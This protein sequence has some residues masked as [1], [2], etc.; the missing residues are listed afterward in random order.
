MTA[1]PAARPGRGPDA[2]LCL[3]NAI[4]GGAPKCGTS[5]VFDWLLQHPDICGSTPK[6]TFYLIDAGYPLLRPWPHYHAGGLAGY[7]PYFELC[8][9]RPARVILD[10]TTHYLYQ[11]TAREVLRGF[12]PRPRAIFIL[13]QPARRIYSAYRY[14]QN[15][16]ACL[17]PKLGFL[18]F[19]E[20][21]LAGA[22]DRL[23]PHCT[24]PGAADYLAQE[25]Q[26]SQYADFLPA[27]DEALGREAVRTILFEDLRAEPHTVM[28]GLFAFLGVRPFTP[29]G[30]WPVKNTTLTL[31]SPRLHRL[32]RSLI[33]RGSAN[34]LRRMVKAA[35]YR[36]QTKPQ[37]PPRSDDQQAGLALLDEHYRPYNE[38]LAAEQGLNLAAWAPAAPRA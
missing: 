1:R 25:V 20:M 12:E 8:R 36:A 22:M 18:P 19:V 7:A 13:R 17:D 33:G 11:R 5:S 4:L 34:L 3:P 35:Y 2:A 37:P 32:A 23:R 15:Q 28:D 10:G 26:R 9:A 30:G 38:R 21:V 6:E 27:W 24:P 16:Q 29:E 31:R 14:A